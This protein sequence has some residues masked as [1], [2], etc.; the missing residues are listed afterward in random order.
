MSDRTEGFYWVKVQKDFDWEVAS[1]NELERRW[2][3]CGE[4]D[5]NSAPESEVVVVGPRIREPDSEVK[6]EMTADEAYEWAKSRKIGDLVE[7]DTEPE[8]E[9]RVVGRIVKFLT[10]EFCEV[11][12]DDGSRHLTSIKYMTP[13]GMG[14]VV[15]CQKPWLNNSEVEPDARTDRNGNQEHAGDDSAKRESR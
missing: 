12:L 10:D 13:P 1:W 5:E 11:E 8:C 14:H 6:P 2:Y 4:G 7:G 9:Q 3:F 15:D